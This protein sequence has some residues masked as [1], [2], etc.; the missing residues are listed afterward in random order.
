MDGIDKITSRINADVDQEIAEIQAQ[1]AAEAAQ[2]AAEYD[3]RCTQETEEILSRGRKTA[4]E[5][6]ERLASVAQLEARKLILAAKQEVLE[7]AFRKALEDL[8][9]LPEQEYVELL[10]KL[11]TKASQ[12]GSEQVIFSQKDRLRY[13]KAAVTRANELLGERGRLTLAVETRPIGGGFILSDGDV[14]VNGTFE[15]LVRMQRH[16]RPPAGFL[17]V[18]L[19]SSSRH[20]QSQ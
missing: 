8:L 6:E 15:T 14:E 19:Y 4:E 7:E 17:A 9:S 12:S 11:I 5:R 2:I 3:Q 16:D 18:I 10:A 1:T 13:G 20:S